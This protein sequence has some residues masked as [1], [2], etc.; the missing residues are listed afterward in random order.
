MK[1]KDT[2]FVENRKAYHD[3][4]IIETIE[5]GIVLNGSEVKLIRSGHMGL[6]GSY[7]VIL[8]G[9]TWLVQS[10]INGNITGWDSIGFTPDKNRKLLLHMREILN[11]KRQTESK[12]LT[13]VPLKVYSRNGRI[14]VLIGLARGRNVADKRENIKNR[15]IN[16]NLRRFY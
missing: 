8:K 1:T 2:T 11:L 9:E 10:S 16:R 5:A 7:V 12:G 13:A 4:Q 14:K 3:Y 6:S 15:E